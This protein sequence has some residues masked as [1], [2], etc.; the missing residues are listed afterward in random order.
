VICP[1]CALRN[2]TSS[3]PLAFSGFTKAIRETVKQTYWKSASKMNENS[4]KSTLAAVVQISLQLVRPVSDPSISSWEGRP[5]MYYTRILA[6]QQHISVQQRTPQQ[7]FEGNCYIS[8]SQIN[9]NRTRMSSHNL[10]SVSHKVSDHHHHHEWHGIAA[11]SHFLVWNFTKMENSKSKIK[12]W[13]DFL[14]FHLQK[15]KKR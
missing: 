13:S 10:V 6:T 15:W 4:P 8:S 14:G 3:T 5:Q 9:T 11:I 1:Y 7:H 12:K 2:I